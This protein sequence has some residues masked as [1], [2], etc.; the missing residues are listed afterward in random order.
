MV[1]PY[2]WQVDWDDSWVSGTSNHTYPQRWTLTFENGDYLRFKS[3]KKGQEI[4]DGTWTGFAT[5][6]S[7]FMG[8]TSGFGIADT[9]YV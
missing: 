3:V 8:Q 6:E 7:R 4:L 9:V 1:L 5:V 2:T